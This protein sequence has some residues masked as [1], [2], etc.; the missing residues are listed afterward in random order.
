MVEDIRCTTTLLY[1]LN[2]DLTYYFFI[3]FIINVGSYAMIAV[4]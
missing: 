3:F 1:N 2:E 4:T